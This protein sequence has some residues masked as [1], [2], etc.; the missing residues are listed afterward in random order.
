MVN[1]GKNVF[2]IL[3]TIYLIVLIA[4]LGNLPKMINEFGYSDYRD[5]QFYS[6]EMIITRHEIYELF[7]NLSK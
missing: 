3:P 6:L 5:K 4:L 1:F 7:L 2:Y